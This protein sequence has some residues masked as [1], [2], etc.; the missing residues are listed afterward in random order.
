MPSITSKRLPE[1]RTLY[2][3]LPKGAEGGKEFSRIVDLLL[4]HEARR[5]GKK[6]TTFSDVA[7]D[8]HGLDSFE[9]DVFRKQG[10][11]GYQYK[12]YPSPLTPAHRKMIVESLKKVAQ[13]ER[14]LKLKKWILV[15]PQD[16]IES[17]TR[18]D[19]GDVTWFES[20]RHELTLRFELE[21]WGHKKLLS[22]FIDTPTLCLF[23][24][25]EL[26]DKGILRKKTIED[27][28][29]RY[30]SNLV[31]LY[32]NIEFVGMSVYKPEATRG[33]P[34]ED[35]Y[36]PLA[37][38]PAEA[39]EVD[40]E[41]GPI[42]PLS[43]LGPGTWRV[44]LGDPGSG[45]STLLRFLAL[46][47]ISEPLQE[48]YGAKPDKR[49]PILV[50]LRRYADE[51]KSRPN[52]SLLDYLQENIQA[53][54][55][56]KSAD[57][58][59]LEYY[60]DNGQTILLFDGLD[61]LPSSHFKQVIRDRI[62]SLVTTYPGNTTIV[63]S[64]IVGYENPFR[65]D[66]KE[67]G[68]Y[69]LT[70][71]RIS[72]MEQFVR[73]WYRVRIE[74]ERERDANINDL[75]RI[76]RNE[77]QT[78]IRELAENPLLL[79]IV[80]LVHRIDAVLPDE[81][82]VLYQK[83]TET[84]L[85]TWH[86]WKFRE[87]ETKNRGKV[88]R[89]NR[90]RMEAIANWMH[91]RSIGI[92]R[93][94]RSVAPYE[95]LLAFLTKYIID[96]ERSSDPDEEPEDLASDFLEFVKKR[97]GLLIE[98]GDN[99]YS[100]VHQT[101]QEYLTSTHIITNNELGGVASIWAS[102]KGDCND[103]R[104]VEVIRLLVAGL[105]SN[106]SQ[107]YLIEKILDETSHD[108]R[109]SASSLLGGILLDGVEPAEAHKEE[110][111]VHLFR[112]AIQATDVEQ[113]RPLISMVRAWLAKEQEN[114]TVL[115]SILQSIAN[116]SNDHDERLS[117]ALIAVAL[118]KHRQG[119]YEWPI[120]ELRDSDLSP[121]F[122]DETGPQSAEQ[123]PLR[124]KR[125]WAE[126]DIFLTT[127][128]FCNLVATVADAVTSSFGLEIVAKRIFFAQL[129]V[130]YPGINSGPFLEYVRNALLLG[131]DPHAPIRPLLDTAG[132]ERQTARALELS[133]KQ[134]AL[135]SALQQLW[136]LNLDASLISKLAAHRIDDRTRRLL[137]N[138]DHPSSLELAWSQIR[139]RTRRKLQKI[140]TAKVPKKE[141]G[142]LERRISP[143][144]ESVILGV[145][146]WPSIL[147]NPKS[148]GDILDFLCDAMRLEPRAQWWE[149]LRVSLLPELPSRMILFKQNTL[150]RVEN[151]LAH[152][153]AGETEYYVAACELNIDSW[154]YQLGYYRSSDETMF[155][156][157]A[158]L[159]QNIN[160]PVLRIAHCIRDLAYGNQSRT[161]DLMSMVGSTDPEYRD[162]FENSLWVLSSERE[163]EVERNMAQRLVSKRM[164]KE[165][166]KRSR[167]S[168]NVKAKMS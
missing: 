112:S 129:M 105:K 158:E 94:Q 44:V 110:I 82:V 1:V 26:V 74:S 50:T 15:T 108:H 48:G 90:H 30:D 140:S 62:L 130:M 56:L 127:S 51:L 63:T 98:V 11:I 149:A 151:A 119:G 60:L 8:Y 88:E 156:R 91:R 19:G 124:I 116:E 163:I 28:R 102:V 49:L 31:K 23:Y 41:I 40:P 113:L 43:F 80:A 132:R 120:A 167:S 165:K 117:L 13:N 73:D 3:I 25:P 89:R 153:T 72:E 144:L 135:G 34:I 166:A 66:E 45:K 32:R 67:F 10:T 71:L 141:S 2:D 138:E 46:A 36:I 139:R 68:H 106:K 92:G 104:W 93:H 103:S 118:N 38:L 101:F 107:E 123:V 87:A 168:G 115:G 164:R 17:S 109:A 83:C 157:L 4:F 61:E 146:P 54:F 39:N 9:G 96:S 147:S 58:D 33:V 65:F 84:L 86:T 57:L 143:T 136:I 75:I 42:N 59:F 12:F 6:V 133:N 52:L 77:E 99:Q 161:R 29:E 14:R 55:N 148:Y 70:K 16:L 35:I 126:Q 79:T 100:F 137:E 159:T 122:L 20:L 85:N 18:S 114:Q 121:L 160:T 27:T 5:V 21:H 125:L 81:R 131:L 155:R 162:I 7:G 142:L 152:G 37:V 64:R 154:L 24:Y 134:T 69:R 22:L 78:A 145:D 95:E 150:E 47:G 128:P 53:D 97:A 76:L 111:L